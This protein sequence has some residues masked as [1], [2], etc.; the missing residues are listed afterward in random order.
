MKDFP[1]FGLQPFEIGLGRVG[2]LSVE[3]RSLV[4]LFVA[5]VVVSL[6]FTVQGGGMRNV[7][8]SDQSEASKTNALEIG[9]ANQPVM[10]SL[11]AHYISNRAPLKPNPFIKLPVGAIKPEGWLRRQLELEAEGFTG[12]LKELSQF[13][14]EE[15]NAWLSPTG[16]GRNHWE[17]VPY[18]LKGFIDLGY[19]LDNQRIIQEAHRWVE[20]AIRSQRPD[21]WF[22]PEANR[23]VG[24]R[25]A[26]GKPD[27]WPNMIMLNVLESYYEYSGDPRV[28]ELMKGYFRWQ[29]QV[30]DA[31]FLAPFWQQQRAG[32]N[33]ASVYWLYNRTG[34]AWLL[35]LATKIHRNMAPWHIEVA[36]WHGVNIC[37]C[38]RAPAIYWMQSHDPLHLAAAERNYQQVMALYGQVPGGMFGADENC[39]PGYDDPRQAAESCSMAEM[40]LSHEMMLTI[41]GERVWADRCEDVAF[42]SFPACMTADL[43]A[44]HYLTAPNMV[45]CDAGSK[46]PGLQN[47]GPMLLFDPY[48]HRC[49]Q[50]NIGHGW[51]RFVQHLWLATPDNGLLAA[52]Y[53]PCRVTALVAEGERIT[54]IEK[55]RYPFESRVRLEFSMERPVVFPVYL[56]VP[57]WCPRLAVWLNGEQIALEGLPSGYLRIQRP[58]RNGD[59][60][61]LDFEM[62]LKVVRWVKNKNSVSVY[63][64]PLA[65]SLKIGEKYVRRGGTDRWPAWEIHPTTPWNYG[66][67]LDPDVPERGFE[68]LAQ[69]WPED[70]QPFCV[71]GAP[72]A[73]RTRAK[74][75]PEWT[76][77]DLGLVGPLC[78]SPVLSD[79]P[80]ETVTLI[81]MG[82]ARL[83]ISSFPTIGTGPEAQRW[84]PTKLGGE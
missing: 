70:D 10:D 39:R 34:D 15:N 54:I 84:V 48:G 28:I 58:W 69:P 41:T 73:L 49:C 78:P 19:V 43:K 27:L 36:S 44:L 37:Q 82:C 53:A 16:E 45:L 33:M 5:A 52:M 4:R 13:L 61:E 2:A 18:W 22:G 11:N 63:R 3:G 12:H 24:S 7:R 62:P 21:G 64:G 76:L 47:S 42:N 29:L 67:I 31:D 14:V 55:T 66:L 72:I 74:K 17:E 1:G 46:S 26:P 50:H 35:D 79:E 30:P 20:A 83:R 8:G 60:L 57:G 6:P 59:Q 9:W 65:F 51:P 38:F 32:D 23:S 81:P 71:D 40:M 68:V 80:E 25:R 56:R 75:I 77:D